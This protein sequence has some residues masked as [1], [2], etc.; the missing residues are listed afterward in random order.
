MTVTV[1]Q[2][3]SRQLSLSACVR[4]ATF[5]LPIIRQ[6]TAKAAHGPA[7]SA[8]HQL[9]EAIRHARALLDTFERHQTALGWAEPAAET[10]DE[11]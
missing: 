8:P 10:P 7:S 3:L 9:S 4:E 1:D 6:S 2:T 11:A 5:R